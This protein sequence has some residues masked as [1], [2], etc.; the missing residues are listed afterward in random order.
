MSVLIVAENTKGKVKAASFEAATYA[1]DL[2][3]SI[4]TDVVA[5]TF[6]D[7]SEGLAELGKYGV[8][9]VLA[10]AN[11]ASAVNTGYANAIVEAA[12]KAGAKHIVFSQSVDSRTIAPR[13]A[14]KL[15]AAMLPGV[16]SLVQNGNTV[17]RMAYSGK[18]IQELAAGKENIVISVK[19]NGYKTEQNQVSCT[20]E[21][22]SP[23]SADFSVVGKVLAAA[24]DTIALP[25]ASVVVS[26]GRG[27]KGPE[28]WGMIEELAKLLGA[29]TACSKPVA[30]VHWRPHQ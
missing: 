6:G 24:T 16:I 21:A 28:N 20:V 5:I 10:V 1:Y 22:F 18:A 9:K 12:G 25:D 8:S 13:V 15:D 19:S 26:A 3:K 29:A 14:V 7:Q 30:D 11:K 4:G 23:A 27:L 17:R 2:A